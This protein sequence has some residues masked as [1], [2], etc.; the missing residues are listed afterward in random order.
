M[1]A[2]SGAALGKADSRKIRQWIADRGRNAIRAGAWHASRWRTRLEDLLRRSEPFPPGSLA[3]R[4]LRDAIEDDRFYLRQSARHG[5]IFKL[6]WGSGQIKT[7]IVGFPLGQR[8]LKAHQDAVRLENI[9]DI[10]SLVPAEYL[11]SMSPELHLKYRRLF[12]RVFRSDL[13]APWEAELRGLL[14]RELTRLAE[15][16]A[17]VAS[18]ARCLYATLDTVATKFLLLT[19]LG[20]TP[21]SAAA[22]ELETWYDRLGPEGRVAQVGPEQKKAFVAIHGIVVQLLHSTGRDRSAP[23]GDSVAKRLM[24]ADPSAVD[25]TVIGN[26]IYMIERGRHDLRDLLRWVVKQLSDHPT[27]TDEIRRGPGNPGAQSGLAEAC[28][29]ETLRLEQAEQLNRRALRSFAFEGFHVPAGSWL[30]IMIRE[31]HRNPE[32]FPEPDT[33]RPHRFLE[34]SYRPDEYAPFGLDEHQ[35]IGA[36]LVV[37]FGTLFVEELVRGF[38]WTV[39]ADGARHHG[40][41]WEPS[42]DFAI[43]LRRC[44]G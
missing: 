35:C 42:P 17:S 37:R 16:A 25:E 6:F 29:L 12:G 41:H 14:R 22:A 44:V 19:M 39:R 31:S 36:S 27:T 13:V 40:V 9:N 32:T 26:V 1:T 23:I 7:C 2:R 11:R 24:D 21:D 10:T 4:H 34:R 30:S 8:L 20:V 5:P 3:A 33:F 43:E 18:P 15:S 38:S 28:V